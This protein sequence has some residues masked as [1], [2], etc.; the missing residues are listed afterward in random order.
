MYLISWSYF[1]LQDE[2]MRYWEDPLNNLP[3][4][5]KE[6]QTF[7][8]YNKNLWNAVT[9]LKVQLNWIDQSV[10]PRPTSSACF[11]QSVHLL[12]SCLTSPKSFAAADL[13]G[14]MDKAFKAL[15]C[16]LCNLA[17]YRPEC[18]LTSHHFLARN[19]NRNPTLCV[20][21]RFWREKLMDGHR[22]EM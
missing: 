9:R 18:L 17:R 16:I 3:H 22:G 4:E 11:F 19:L 12:G 20:L 1:S 13:A 2:K 6:T 14:F 7:D 10:L 15:H 21:F 5:R 8:K